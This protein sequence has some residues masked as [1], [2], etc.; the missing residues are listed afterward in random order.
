MTVKDFVPNKKSVLC[1]EHFEKD[2]FRKTGRNACTLTLKSNA[3]PTI[4]KLP[5]IDSKIVC[6]FYIFF[7]LLLEYNAHYGKILFLEKRRLSLDLPPPKMSKTDTNYSMVNPMRA[8]TTDSGE[9]K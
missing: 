5:L 4:F 1:S 9:F 2:C 3:V 6:A 8:S 7:I